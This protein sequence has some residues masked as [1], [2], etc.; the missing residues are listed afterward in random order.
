M[1]NTPL[2]T[3]QQVADT[4]QC[5]VANVRRWVSSHQLK[6]VKLG[7]R[8]HRVKQ[9]EFDAFIKRRSTR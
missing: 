7:H 5:S 9:D 1:A 4:A 3:Y 2:L 6:A 8:L